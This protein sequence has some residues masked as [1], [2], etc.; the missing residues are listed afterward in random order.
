MDAD[1]QHPPELIPI[2]LQKYEKGKNIVYARPVQKNLG[3]FKKNLSKWY[4]KILSKISD[5]QIPENV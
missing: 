4:Y 3:F 1:L 2:M 5:T